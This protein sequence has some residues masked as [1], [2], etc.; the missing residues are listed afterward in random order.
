MLVVRFLAA[1]PPHVNDD[2]KRKNANVPLSPERP[3]LT[4]FQPASL[5]AR[6]S[7]RSAS[8]NIDG[9]TQRTST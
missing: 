8:R 6:L 3:A 4:G 9:A 1:L 2:L 7:R 5:S